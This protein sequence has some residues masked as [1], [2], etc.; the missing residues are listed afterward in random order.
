MNDG[1]NAANRQQWMRSLLLVVAGVALLGCVVFVTTPGYINPYEHSV[2]TDVADEAYSDQDVIQYEDLS[3]SGQSVFLDALDSSSA[4]YTTKP[5]PEFEYLAR[6]AES[7]RAT[8]IEYQ[9]TVYVME[10]DERSGLDA[11]ELRVIQLGLTVLGIGLLVG[12]VWPLVSADQTRRR[13]SS[14]SPILQAVHS[15]STERLVTKWLPTVCFTLLA[16]P[17]LIAATAGLTVGL[18]ILIPGLAPIGLLHGL[19][20]LTLGSVVG[21]LIGAPST[22]AFC[23]LF[24]VEQRLFYAATVFSFVAWAV[25]AFAYAEI[26]LF[27]AI[28]AIVIFVFIG[29]FLLGY[30]VGQKAKEDALVLS[31]R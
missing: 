30:Q 15:E 1:E 20:V 6:M 18:F 26:V 19:L 5:V 24:G 12:G 14:R 17:V 23:W 13:D 21:V 9:G 7:P 31:N 10:T 3:P 11:I 4:V 25:T 29:P 8:V 27:S 28:F 22:A 2:S 16:P